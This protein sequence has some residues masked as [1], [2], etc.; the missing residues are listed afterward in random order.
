MA[1]S[2][3][4][5]PSAGRTQ[6]PVRPPPYNRPVRRG[7]EVPTSEHARGRP[8]TR[9][10]VLLLA[11]VLVGCQA[12]VSPVPSPSATPAA[13]A[14]PTASPTATP[15]DPGPAHTPPDLSKRPLIFFAPLPPQRGGP[16]DGSVDWSNLWIE[17]ADWDELAGQLDLFKLYGGWSFAESSTPEV[18]RIRRTLDGYGLGLAVETSPLFPADGCGIDDQGFGLE[19][20][21]GEQARDTMENIRKGGGTVD[22]ITLDEPWY[23]AHLY[24][25]PGACNWDPDRIAAGVR[26]FIAVVRQSFPNVLVGDIEPTPSPVSAAGLGEWIDAWTRVVGEPPA[27]LHLDVDVGRANWID[28]VADI[29]TEAHARDVPFGV[30]GIGDP[31][32]GSDLEWLQAGGARLSRLRFLEGVEPD[33]LIFQSWHDRPDRALPESDPTTYTGWLLEYLRDPLSEA[34]IGPLNL[35]LTATAKASS[36]VPSNPAS[37]VNDASPAHWNAAN[38]PPQYVQ[39]ALKEPSTIR[40]FVLVVAQDPAGKSVHELWVRK[41]GGTLQRV[42]VFEGV[43]KEGDVL[44]YE[45]TQPLVDI[46]LVRV[47][48]TSLAGGLWPAWHEIELIGMR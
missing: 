3:W 4:L 5:G 28:L 31:F 40:R 26:D 44:V 41:L 1:T 8:V 2:S 22:L 45:P 24:D 13:T 43:T 16:Y 17:G 12:T 19:G 37:N 29:G 7:R 38:V 48:T 25:G 14:P 46:D 18:D 33:H 34:A 35:A 39:L 20:F 15:T 47:V 23:Y 11:V 27:F 6:D 36:A 32:A 21:A 30:I 42:H 9:G 10:A